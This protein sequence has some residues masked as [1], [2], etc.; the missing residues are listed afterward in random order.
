MPSDGVIWKEMGGARVSR[1]W[2][3]SFF[4]SDV[5]AM[6]IGREIEVGRDCCNKKKELY[7][8]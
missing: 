1:F 3:S 5:A 7:F 8:L 6:D 4:S 2:D